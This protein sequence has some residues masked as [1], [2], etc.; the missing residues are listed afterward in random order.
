MKTTR[1]HD[2]NRLEADRDKG[3]KD[4]RRILDKVY[5]QAKDGEL[6]KLRKQLIEAVRR[7]D[8]PATAYLEKIIENYTRRRYGKS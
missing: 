8:H 7:N 5:K 1:D 4:A 2:L 6:E 3:F